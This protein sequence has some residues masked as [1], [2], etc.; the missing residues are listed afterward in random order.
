MLCFLCFPVQRTKATI[1]STQ[2]KYWNSCFLKNEN[3]GSKLFKIKCV[4]SFKKKYFIKST[5]TRFQHFWNIKRASF[6]FLL[7]SC[8]SLKKLPKAEN[9][10][11]S[12]NFLQIRKLQKTWICKE[13]NDKTNAFTVRTAMLLFSFKYQ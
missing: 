2:I 9:L 8:V 11:V 7:V 10:P 12:W 4:T 3:L 13:N 5:S 1:S 6:I